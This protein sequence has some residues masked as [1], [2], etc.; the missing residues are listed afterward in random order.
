MVLSMSSSK[1]VKK[2]QVSLEFLFYVISVLVAI[3]TY[4]YLINNQYDIKSEIHERN[5]E[6]FIE[7]IKDLFQYVYAQGDG[8]Y[9]NYSFPSDIN[10]RKYIIEVK[11]DAL[12]IETNSSSYV[13]T[14]PTSE[15]NITIIPGKK[16]LIENIEGEIYGT[17]Y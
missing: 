11:G 6:I 14:L 17:P 13:I 15:T 1:L 12:V 9:I 5:I 2:V 16:H 3:T 10:G 7:Q 4:I 8:F